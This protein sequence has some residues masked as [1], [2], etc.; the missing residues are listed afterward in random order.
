MEQT[1]I[2]SLVLDQTNP[3]ISFWN[4]VAHCDAPSISG[5]RRAHCVPAG[6]SNTLSAHSRASG[7]RARLEA[8]ISRE[9]Q[10]H[11]GARVQHFMPVL[12]GLYNAD[13][14][15]SAVVG[16]RSAA[17]ERL[18][19]E[20]YTREPVEKLMARKLGVS[21]KREE[22]IEVG[23]LACTSGYAATSIVR[24]LVPYFIG[25]GFSWVVFTAADTVMN[26][27][28]RLSLEPQFL[29]EADRSML[30]DEADAWGAYYDHHPMVMAGCLVD[31]MSALD[32]VAGLQ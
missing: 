22:I 6:H 11:F 5:P 25:A 1:F 20:A 24:A 26:V 32:G 17:E 18:F 29:C 19:L 31:G 7:E 30:G 27:F 9:F 8:F 4:F 14:S 13:R 12:V 15:V 21:V 23:S 2:D 28:R 10:E 16:C 3:A